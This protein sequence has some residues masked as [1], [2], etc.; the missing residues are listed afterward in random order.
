MDGNQKLNVS[1]FGVFA[2]HNGLEK[3]LLD[4]CGLTFIYKR[5]SVKMLQKGKKLTSGCHPWLTNVCA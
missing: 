2:L 1:F 4:I 3:L 5:D